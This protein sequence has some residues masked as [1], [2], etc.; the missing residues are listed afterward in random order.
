MKKTCLV[1]VMFAL[2]PALSMA[3]KSLIDSLHAALKSANTDSARFTRLTDLYSY[4]VES[5]RDSALYY[6]SEAFFITT[7]NNKAMEQ[8]LVLDDKGYILMHLDKYPES[9][10]AFQQALKLAEDPDNENKAWKINYRNL[11]NFTPHANRVAILASIH[12]DMGHL[13]GN[14]NNID[15]QI[16]QYR[17]TRQLAAQA[18]ESQ[19]L[20]L[21]NMNLGRVYTGL[22]HLDSALAME[23]GAER[24][25]NQ[26]GFKTYIGDVYEFIGDIYLK[27]GN[28]GIAVQY[29]YKAINADIAYKDA[30]GT[31]ASYFDLANYY[32][33]KKK[34]DSSLYYSKRALE[35]L[36]SMGSKDLAQAYENLCK[37]YK[38]TGNTDSAYKY[39][40]LA[41]TVKDS[42]SKATIKSLGDFQKLSF[43]AQLHAQELEK[44]QADTQART[45][46]YFLLAAVGVL[47]LLAAVF[48]RN[49]RHKQKVNNLL[50]LQKE[51]IV[52]QKEQI[53]SQR[54][55]LEVTLNNLKTAQTQLIQ[56]EKMASLGEL[57]AGIAHEIQ[58]P[59]N[60]VN[61]FS[62]VN[63]ELI[64]EMEQEIE[65]GDLAEI[66]AI[67][68]DLKENE[69]K[70]TLHG[71]RAG[72]IVKGMLQH[73]QMHNGV[74]EPVDLNALADEYMRLAYQGLKAKDPNFNAELVTHFDE[75]LPKANAVAQDIGRVMLN[76]FNNAFYA[77]NQKKKTSGADY[78]PGV[79]VKTSTENGQIIIKVKDNGVGIPDAIKDK[80][81]QPFFTTRP[82]GEGI[83]LGLSLTYDMV[84]KGHG[85]NIT[86]NSIAGDGSEFIISLPL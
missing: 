32:F 57:T 69:N 65:K 54:D 9:L 49:N 5:N 33:D 71:K 27:K 76:L 13:M 6:N 78:K 1:I 30:S 34:T 10:Q 86:V 44:E 42:T 75:S 53:E 62:E 26:T 58:N 72:A 77:V 37:A 59:L 29:F 80:I 2:I 14:T 85:G 68:L 22:N 25:F 56:S 39:Q 41:L 38:L 60:F 52:Q 4:Y 79:A 8:A 48:Y 81:M 55:D 63:V 84:V 17:L 51:E 19:L 24:I 73:S 67:A 47:M 70:I 7:K 64:G 18:D 66:K 83:G 31:V 50:L 46:I 11:K 20:G 61:N 23:Q 16:A 82:T 36:K 12:H 3:Q 74:K 15:Q 43:R 35:T 21:V 28:S 45:R 40:G